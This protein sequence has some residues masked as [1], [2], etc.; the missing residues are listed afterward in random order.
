MMSIINPLEVFMIS[1]LAL[2]EAFATVREPVDHQLKCSVPD[3]QS[4][5]ALTSTFADLLSCEDFWSLST[6]LIWQAG[7]H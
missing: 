6:D 4:Y 2:R 5:E 1:Y 7:K 3:P